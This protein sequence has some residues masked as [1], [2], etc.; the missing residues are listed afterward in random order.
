MCHYFYEHGIGE[1]SVPMQ[2]KKTNK[3]MWLWHYLYKY[4]VGVT[5]AIFDID[6]ILN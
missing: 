3:L 6:L 5:I 2:N 4:G 1:C